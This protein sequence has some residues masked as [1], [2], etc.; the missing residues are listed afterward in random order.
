MLDTDPDP[1]EMN[2]DPQPCLEC[3]C[4]GSDMWMPQNVYVVAQYADVVPQNVNVVAQ[5]VDVVAQYVD[6]VA[7]CGDLVAQCGDVVLIMALW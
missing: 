4:D 3:G 6:V 7:Q 5:Y 2:A 1:D